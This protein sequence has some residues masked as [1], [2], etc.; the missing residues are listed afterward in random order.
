MRKAMKVFNG[1]NAELVQDE[2]SRIVRTLR[3]TLP[4]QKG[5]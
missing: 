5:A 1:T 4:V 3:L 2:R